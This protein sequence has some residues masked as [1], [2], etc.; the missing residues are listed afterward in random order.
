[1]GCNKHCP[2]L[3]IPTSSNTLRTTPSHGTICYVFPSNARKERVGKRS[4]KLFSRCFST[5]WQSRSRGEAGSSFRYLF[6]Q[7]QPRFFG[8]ML[9]WSQ[10]SAN[11]ITSKMGMAGFTAGSQT[12]EDL[13]SIKKKKLFFKTRLFFIPQRDRKLWAIN[14]KDFFSKITAF[15]SCPQLE[16]PIFS[17]C[18]A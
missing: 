1:M 17:T 8:S 18:F 15:E 10:T 11:N 6:P 3:N 2:L 13:V 16:I 12:K 14:L 4:Q 7:P 9:R 5:L